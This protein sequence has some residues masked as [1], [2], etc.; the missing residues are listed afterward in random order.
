MLMT[1]YRVDLTK[2]SR[3][4]CKVKIETLKIP[5]S[6]LTYSLAEKSLPYLTCCL[7]FILIVSCCFLNANIFLKSKQVVIS[8]GKLV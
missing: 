7:L 8:K 2:V 1:D 6:P 4:K 5:Y 3:L